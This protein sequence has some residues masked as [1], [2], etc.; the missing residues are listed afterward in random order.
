MIDLTK[1]VLELLKT[2]LKVTEEVGYNNI[3]LQANDEDSNNYPV[4]DPMITYADMGTTY[5]R[6]KVLSL[7]QITV[8]S[9]EKIKTLSIIED[10]IPIFNEVKDE[11]LEYSWIPWV[12]PLY[13]HKEKMYWSAVTLN[14]ITRK[15]KG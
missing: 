15:Y 14:I 1:R 10:I 2:S 9:K 3:H 11:E 8:R 12:I 5:A 13:D 4:N 7:Y 6:V